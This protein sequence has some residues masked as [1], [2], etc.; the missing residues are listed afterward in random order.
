MP[1]RQLNGWHYRFG[2]NG[3]ENDNEVKGAGNQQDYGMRVYDGRIARFLSVDPLTKSYPS[4]SP[5]PF[6]M[7]RP[8]DG[9]DLDGLE[10][11]DVDQI[12]KMSMWCTKLGNGTSEIIQA[13]TNSGTN[14][15]PN[16]P[17]RI[18]RSLRIESAGQGARKINEAVTEAGEFAAETVNN[19]PG[20]EIV[21]DP[22]L[23]SYYLNKGDY[24]SAAIYGTAATIPLVSGAVLEKAK[25]L[26]ETLIKVFKNGVETEA[27]ALRIGNYGH[28]NTPQYKIIKNAIKKG[29]N[30]VAKS[31]EEALLFIKDA[32]GDIENQTGRAE[33]RKGY[34]IDKEESPRTGNKQGHTGNHI[35][36]YDKDAGIEVNIVIET[37]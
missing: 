11:V 36:Y 8:I 30:F 1:G 20:V 15:D 26:S 37:K 19:I 2:F 27:K 35:N 32:F 7:N 16:I 4:M 12:V 18:Q 14:S 17:R 10:W 6:S 13:S 33:G 31:E 9:I 21:G 23:S 29:G 28:I 5:Y 24:Y 25:P 34:R 22:L 3:K